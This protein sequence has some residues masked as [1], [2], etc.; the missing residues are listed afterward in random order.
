MRD[1]SHGRSTRD[2]SRTAEWEEPFARAVPRAARTHDIVAATD[3]S[4]WRR[5]ALA[6]R[7]SRK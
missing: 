4:A 7:R 3:P 2:V 5:S 1:A 6:A